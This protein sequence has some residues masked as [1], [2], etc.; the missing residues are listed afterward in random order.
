M[1]TKQDPIVVDGNEI[2]KDPQS[3]LTQMCDRLDLPFTDKMLSW[4][5]GLKSCDGVWAKFWY[6]DLHSTTGF[7][8]PSGIK[9]TENDIPMEHIPFYREVLPYYQKLLSHS[10]RA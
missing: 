7:R 6:S 2:R 9:I 4:P 1:A 5:T 8:P 10:I 3:V